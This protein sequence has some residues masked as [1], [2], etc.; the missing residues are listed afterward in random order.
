MA[1]TQTK[2]L[3]HRNIIIGALIVLVALAL[4]NLS[5]LQG[6]YMNPSSAQGNAAL[7]G[8]VVVAHA[9]NLTFGG[10]GP[11]IYNITLL[12]KG[13]T[14][15]INPHS[16]MMFNFSI[17]ANASSI[18]LSGDYGSQG[19]VET[20]V[21]SNAQYLAFTSDASSI[22]S[23]PYYYGNTQGAQI[24]T[25][26]GIPAGNYTLLFYNAGFTYDRVNA[27]ASLV[28]SYTS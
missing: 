28:V 7:Q 18:T 5:G 9:S 1:K 27:L 25:Y 16:Y 24:R 6:I 13:S 3:N 12:S 19:L 2:K 20:A 21:L 26:L 17:P 14:Y 22:T 23:T 15:T 10:S 4:F 8:N 11:Q